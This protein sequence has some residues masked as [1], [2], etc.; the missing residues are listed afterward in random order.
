MS[1]AASSLVEQTSRFIWL[2][3]P[4]TVRRSSSGISGVLADGGY[5]VAWPWVAVLAPPLSFV[6][7]LMLGWQ[8]P[9]EIFTNSIL[10]VSGMFLVANFS[11]ALGLWMWAGFLLG[12]FFHPHFIVRGDS[13]LPHL[14]YFWMPLVLANLLLGS[15]LV[16]VSLTARAL[17]LQTSTDLRLKPLHSWQKD[18]VLHAFIQMALVWVW[19]QSVPPLVRPVWTW[20][21]L[22]IPVDHIRPLQHYGW[23]LAL[24]AGFAAVARILLEHRATSQASV[25]AQLRELQTSSAHVETQGI[26]HIPVPVSFALKAGFTTFMFSG[27]ITRWWEALELMLLFLVFF[28]LRAVLAT[29]LAVWRRATSRVSL[30][31]RLAGASAM[32][33]LLGWPVLARLWGQGESFQSII[34]LVGFSLLMV[35]VMAPGYGI[36]VKVRAEDKP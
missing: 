7:G 29:H 22:I 10:M 5:L 24:A 25:L 11:S 16:F 30:L 28:C 23:I 4:V 20:Q 32:G 1:G 3:V 12:D 34:V 14:L 17:R 31:V 8:H 13:F 33:A 35:T 19:T 18:A 27:L 2:R 15:L 9:G 36:P 21:Q 26:F 6:A